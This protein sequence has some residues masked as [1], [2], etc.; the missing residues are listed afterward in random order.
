M[1]LVGDLEIAQIVDPLVTCR[2]G[3]RAGIL[4]ELKF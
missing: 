3:I 1:S 2:M 4:P